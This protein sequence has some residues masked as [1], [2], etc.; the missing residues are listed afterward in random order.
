MLKS[1][2]GYFAGASTQYGSSGGGNS[3]LIGSTLE[4]GNMTLRVKRVIAEGGFAVVFE[5]VDLA[6]NK[7]CAVKR[8]IGHDAE[9]KQEIEQEIKFLKLLSGH[10]NIIKFITAASSQNPQSGSTEYLVVM[11]YC[12]K[13]RL[14]DLL[15]TKSKLSVQEVIGYFYQIARAVQHLHCQTPPIIHRDLK[16][17]NVLINS[18]GMLKLCDFGSATTQT[19]HPDYSWSALKR[20]QVEDECICHTTPMYRTPE[21]LDLYQNFPIDQQQDVWAL[22]CTLYLLCFGFHPFEDSAKLRILNANYSLAN[23]DPQYDVV[24][25][26][27]K[28]C[29]MVDPRGRP[30]VNDVVQRIEEIAE[31]LQIN[32]SSLLKKSANNSPMH[33]FNAAVPKT[34]TQQ[35]RATEPYKS[36]NETTAG[37]DQYPSAGHSEQQQPSNAM[38]NSFKSGASSFFSNM[39]EASNK[40]VET[41]SNYTKG[42]LD[43]SYITS[44]ILVMSYPAEGI[45]GA[46]K[47][48]IEDVKAFLDSRHP[49]RYAVYNLTLSPYRHYKFD[50][51]V[52]DCGW[53]GKKSPSLMNLL[54]ICKN[55]YQWLKMHSSNVAV[56]HCSDG[57]AQSA[58]IVAAF[59][60]FC[61]MYQNLGPS[62]HLFTVKRTGPGI[63]PSHKRYIEYVADI[64]NVDKKFVPHQFQVRVS[65]LILRPVP[66]INSQ[67][68][69]CKPFCEVY[70]N[71]NRI[72]TTSQE[73]ENIPGFDYHR[74]DCVV[75]P[76]DIEL[77]GDIT[78]IVYHARSILGGKVQ[79]KNISLKMF[80]FQFNTGFLP[81]NSCAIKFRRSDLDYLESPDRYPDMFLAMLNYEILKNDSDSPTTKK[82]PYEILNSKDLSPYLVVKDDAEMNEVYKLVGPPEPRTHKAH[83]DCFEYTQSSQEANVPRR[84]L[85]GHNVQS[86]QVTS[87]PNNNAPQNHDADLISSLYENSNSNPASVTY[88]NESSTQNQ[89]EPALLDF[90]D[91]SPKNTAPADNAFGNPFDDFGLQGNTFDPFSSQTST[92]NANNADVDLFANSP[93]KSENQQTGFVNED[94][95]VNQFE[96]FDLNSVGNQNAS[97]DSHS[98]TASVDLLGDWNEVINV[99]SQPSSLN[100]NNSSQNWGSSNNNLSNN[101]TAGSNNAGPATSFTENIPNMAKPT[102]IPDVTKPPPTSK[103]S[104]DLGFDPFGSFDPFSDVKSFGSSQQKPKTTAGGA[105]NDPNRLGTHNIPSSTSQNTRSRSVSPNPST[106][107]PY[108]SAGG[109]P[110]G[111]NSTNTSS[112]ANYNINIPKSNPATNKT[113]ISPKAG[114]KNDFA[115]LL[116]GFNVAGASSV[117]GGPK[118]LKDLKNEQQAE[119]LDPDDVKIKSWIDGKEGNIRALLCSLHKVVWADSPW[120]EC[121]MHQLVTA[122]DVKK[123]WRKALLATH[124]D[125]QMG[126]E[127]ENLS[128]KIMIEL[129]DAWEKYQSSGA[130]SLY[131][132]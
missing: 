5:A 122:S 113:G 103:S 97:T 6:S 10:P 20:S 88:A 78:F 18:R 85:S 29:L 92:A 99:S 93:F 46:V 55:M 104:S 9:K 53:P 79:A 91:M 31:A 94:P 1:A 24:H 109:M 95:L 14:T 100:F 105:S 19:Y 57:K 42:E 58:L 131:G 43:I 23:K 7:T 117:G 50:N 8:L 49:K 96:N 4:L 45:Q 40:M 68:V 30:S 82:F 11:E 32:L 65:N 132:N 70:R 118:S 34:P 64:C 119:F 98:K 129:N 61:H 101:W 54:I 107:V 77:S 63:L 17:E 37:P 44:R 74:D 16:L 12:P 56:I 47:N 21:M 90:G 62:L 25:D 2:L 115:D 66:T 83:E 86:E 110:N 15:N 33:E 76:L 48:N 102:S 125:K 128:K 84:K 108:S 112:K 87:L 121:G 106:R 52:S 124:P 59:F 51:R 127:N 71:E 111:A 120:E 36:R 80:Q 116:G 81:L 27:I 73:Y 28:G 126:T 39:K 130:Q 41:V 26:L 13:G 69:G 3:D 114:R 67:R 123:M 89:E 22:G 75:I 35:P 60:A 72:F 38:F